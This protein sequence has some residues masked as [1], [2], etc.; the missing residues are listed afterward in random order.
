M[1]LVGVM[2]S[3]FFMFL[4][5]LC[6]CSFEEAV[7]SS[8][9]FRLALTDVGLRLLVGARVL[10]ELGVWQNLAALAQWGKAV[11]PLALRRG[12]T[13]WAL[14]ISIT[15][16]QCCPCPWQWSLLGFSV[17]KAVGVI[18]LSFPPLRRH[19]G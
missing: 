9:I 13:A 7:T 4:I 10:A 17:S 18:L 16:G 5:A 2:F 19:Y 8:R 6:W 11:V 1:L 12:T 3:W 14:S 15:C